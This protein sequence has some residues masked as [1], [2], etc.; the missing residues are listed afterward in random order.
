MLEKTA[1]NA[2]HVG[3]LIGTVLGVVNHFSP[4]EWMVIGI[5]V[6][7][8]CSVIG[9]ITSV[10]FKCRR[11]KLLKMYLIDRSAKGISAHDVNLIEGD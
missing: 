9:C 11:E 4:A 5:I 3:W 1:D 7:I 2:T 10:W 8:L 6:G